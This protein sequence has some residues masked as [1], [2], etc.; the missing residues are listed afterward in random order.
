[1]K[2]DVARYLRRPWLLLSDHI[3]RLATTEAVGSMR[4]RTLSI[5]RWIAFAG[6]LFTV[7]FVHFSLGIRLPIWLLLIAVGLIAVTN[8]TLSVRGGQERLLNG[9]QA[10]GLFVFDITQLSVMLGL[11]GGLQN[12]FALLLLL[13]VALAATTLE[14]YA[15]IALT[16][17][18]LVGLTLIAFFHW[19]LPWPGGGLR[20]PTLYQAATW[21]ALSLA[22]MLLATYVW[23]LA[24]DSRLHAQ[25]FAE[26]QLALAREQQLSALGGQAA[27]VA[28]MLGTPLGTINV[29]AKE[30]VREL[31]DSHPLSEDARDLL[32]Q[33]YRCRDILS[34]LGKPDTD[35]RHARFTA[36]PLSDHLRSIADTYGHDEAKVVI[37]NTGDSDLPEPVLA[38]PPEVRHAFANLIENACS[39]AKTKVEIGLR[40]GTDSVVV[41][42]QDDGPGFPAGVLDRIGDPYI[43]TRERTGGLGLGLF[44]ANS[45]LARTGAT[46]HFGNTSYGAQVW[47]EWPRRV[48]EKVTEVGDG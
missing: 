15:T 48:L 30:L 40:S 36:A 8:L 24:N 35:Q 23:Q 43:S 5:I 4:I 17:L 41:T 7:L 31:P 11:T 25:A 29:V 46:L 13:P 34:T 9:R 45:L 39:Y 12:P 18:T 21:V 22:I 19:P 27:A 3:E 6:Q 26:T 28:H 10:M 33:A 16:L 44:I 37:R 14:R 20:I 42:I 32:A 1:M 38:L 47:I 2:E